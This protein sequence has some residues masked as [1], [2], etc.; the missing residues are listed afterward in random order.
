MVLKYKKRVV[1]TLCTLLTYQKYTPLPHPSFR[2]N[3]SSRCLLPF[4]VRARQR[5]GCD[6]QRTAFSEGDCRKINVVALKMISSHLIIASRF[7]LFTVWERIC[8]NSGRG[9]KSELRCRCANISLSSYLPLYL[10]PPLQLSTGSSEHQ[11]N[12]ENVVAGGKPGN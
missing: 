5:A 9:K 4:W 11:G 3:P 7:H 1:N 6:Q 10:F 2:H 12:S 8:G